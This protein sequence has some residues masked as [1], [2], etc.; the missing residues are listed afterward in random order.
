[1]LFKI[2]L[3]LRRI[4]PLRLRRTM[5]GYV[6][7]TIKVHLEV[8]VSRTLSVVCFMFTVLGFVIFIASYANT[9]I[10]A[11]EYFGSLLSNPEFSSVADL[12]CSRILA[13]DD[14]VYL[15]RAARNRI[16]YK[17]ELDLP[18]DCDTVRQRNRFVEQP[19]SL[20]EENFPIAISRVVHKDYRLLEMGLAANYAPQ[21]WYCFAMDSKAD[22]VFKERVLALSTCF[23]N[24]IV[25]QVHYR[26]DS[27]GHNMS[28]SFVECLKNLAERSKKWEYVILV[29]NNDISVR[30]NEELVQI[31]KW[32]NGTND[33][34][35]V[36]VPDDERINYNLD[37]T[38]EGLELFRNNTRNKIAPSGQTPQLKF[39][40]GYAHSCFSR[41]A[42]D[43]IVNELDVSKVLS[44]M[45]QPSYGVDEVF[46]PSLMSTEALGV[47]G[48]FTHECLDRGFPV[49]HVTVYAIWIDK[50][51]CRSGNWRHSVCVLGIEDLPYDFKNSNYLFVNKLMPGFDFG[52]I[53]CW[54]DELHYR[55]T[56]DRGLHRLDSTIY[57]QLPQV[58]YNAE[59]RRTGRVDM[60]R[61]DCTSILNN[62]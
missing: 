47:P 4:P 22:I 21:N 38:F 57:K 58:R 46:W 35:I 54:F 24:V 59:K 3:V 44:Q 6:H 17:D 45:E 15:R 62:Y 55:T 19:A 42:A 28:A 29:Q 13:G 5:H 2:P 30:T 37:W 33:V 31:F 16:R 11:V 60:N 50:A 27:N 25:N 20:E 8:R 56:V 9:G 1:M 14:P 23:P 41:P 39:A 12:N 51:K 49:P 7:R 36:P 10:S 48:G 18:M 40:K 32:F 34:M 61:F 43:F 52:A 53:K 26:L